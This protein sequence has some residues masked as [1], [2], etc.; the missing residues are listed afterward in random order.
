MRTAIILAG[1]GS[2][3]ME[4]DKGLIV[5]S[6]EPMVC[7]VA[8][9]LSSVV[10]EL[11][12]VVGSNEQ[13]TEYSKVLGDQAEILVDLYR[14]GS[15]LVGAITA[16]QK[17]KAKFALITGCDMPF[18]SPEIV[19]WLFKEAEGYDGAV[20]EWKNGWI[21]PLLA[22]YRIEPSLEIANELMN[23]NNLRLRMI[24]NRLPNIKRIPMDQLKERDPNLHTLFDV[25]TV[26]AITEAEKILKKRYE[27]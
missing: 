26:D 16:F 15:P 11:L 13:K 6:S 3:R 14:D 25:D 23:E 5:L 4:R 8:D 21:E 19:Q 17:T 9:I 12:V 1:G 18:I 24:L 10:D 7:R 20:F 27:D 22:V 2:T